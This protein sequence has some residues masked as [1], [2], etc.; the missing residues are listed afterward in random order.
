MVICCSLDAKRRRT[1]RVDNGEV[2][3]DRDEVGKVFSLMGMRSAPLLLHMLD[4]MNLR[5]RC[6][7][8]MD[9]LCVSNSA[10]VDNCR[11]KSTC[12]VER[13]KESQG[14]CTMRKLVR[15]EQRAA[16][17]YQPCFLILLTILTVPRKD[18][19]KRLRQRSECRR[20]LLRPGRSW[21]R[22]LLKSERT[23]FL[24]H[25]AST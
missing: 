24:P 15:Y 4:L 12:T 14:V 2:Q 20:F 19:L 9:I 22:C 7:G 3:T 17:D 11:P 16:D 25:K 21:K 23:L 10:I 18:S 8:V 5:S 1:L 13:M 6:G